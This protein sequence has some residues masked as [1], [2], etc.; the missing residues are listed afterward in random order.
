MKK[1]T[2]PTPSTILHKEQVLEKYA[3]VSLALQGAIVDL[4]DIAACW[5]NWSSEDAKYYSEQLGQMLSCDDGEA[6][7]ES[8]IRK[9]VEQGVGYR[10][11]GLDAQFK[12]C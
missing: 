7:I 2:A 8:L 5:R 4:Q 11:R 3:K 9:L 10:V 1:T 12:K 6:G